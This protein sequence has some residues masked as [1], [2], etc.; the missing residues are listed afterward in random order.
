MRIGTKDGATDI[1]LDGETTDKYKQYKYTKNEDDV[2]VTEDINESVIFVHNLKLTSTFSVT[3]NAA[4]NKLLGVAQEVKA[5]KDNEI[6]QVSIGYQCTPGLAGIS[7][8]Y[9]TFFLDDEMCSTNVVGIRKKC[10]SNSSFAALEIAE[11]SYW[12]TKKNVLTDNG[13]LTNHPEN[14][15]D[16]AHENVVI[17]KK[18]KQLSFRVTNTNPVTGDS[19]DDI[20][21]D[22]PIV[23]IVNEAENVVYPVLRGAGARR[24]T[25]SPGEYTD[26]KLEFNCISLDKK[27][28]GIELLF[29]PSFHSVYKFKLTK[30][31]EGLTAS[32]LIKKKF[33][34]SLIFDFFAFLFITTA[35]MAFTITVFSIYI[36]YKEMQGEDVDVNK[37]FSKM[38]DN[39]K[40][41]ASGVQSKYKDQD[42]TPI[43]SG[44]FDRDDEERTQITDIE[45]DPNDMIKETSKKSK[46][47][48]HDDEEFD[49]DVKVDFSKDD[50]NYP[51]HEL[52][53]VKDPNKEGAYGA[54]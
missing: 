33:E 1:M 11:T 16:S 36:K 13:G 45:F 46:R 49:N 10:G 34:D 50:E 25:L 43:R 17:K 38:W 18:S 5:I 48:Q 35:T 44:D 41:G 23:R 37:M 32:G 4:R 52:K 27:S 14:L 2:E 24:H 8:V 22:P 15:F 19:S 39:I 30:E 7:D 26:F 40:S 31:C 28:E 9:L 6:Y 20:E 12:G 54:M 42:F 53:E 47:N 3:P 51:S 29:R 21:M